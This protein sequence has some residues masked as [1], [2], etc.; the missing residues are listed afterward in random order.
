M[1]TECFSKRWATLNVRRGLSPKAE[2]LHYFQLATMSSD[3][4]VHR[5]RIVQPSILYVTCVN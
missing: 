5:R 4:Q 1:T 2:V 3:K